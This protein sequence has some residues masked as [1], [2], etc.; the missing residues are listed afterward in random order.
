MIPPDPV[1]ESGRG[2]EDVY[3]GPS[4]M[5]LRQKGIFPPEALWNSTHSMHFPW[6]GHSVFGQL[7]LGLSSVMLPRLWS[8]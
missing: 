6:R 1:K 8:A 3:W 4:T 5:N 7:Q 2:S